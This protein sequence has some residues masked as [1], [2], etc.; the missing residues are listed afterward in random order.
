[1]LSQCGVVW[2]ASDPVTAAPPGRP[3][4]P[5][6]STPR[7]AQCPVPFPA[8]AVRGSR[9]TSEIPAVPEGAPG[10]LHWD[11]S[12]GHVW[13]DRTKGNERLRTDKGHV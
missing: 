10:E 11:L 3:P 5:P 2:Y 12:Q 1:M 8:Q 9:E 7:R 6:G 13:S 4:P